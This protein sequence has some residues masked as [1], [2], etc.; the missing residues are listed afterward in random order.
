MFLGTRAG[1]AGSL[2]GEATPYFQERTVSPTEPAPAETPAAGAQQDRVRILDDPHE[3]LQARIDLIEQAERTLDVSYYSFLYGPSTEAVIALLAD[4]ADRGVRV[5]LILD[6]ITNGLEPAYRPILAWLLQHENLEVRFFNPPRGERHLP[7]NNRLHIKILMADDTQ[8]ISGGRNI[9]DEYFGIERGSAKRQSRD[10]DLYIR[11]LPD[12]D[13]VTR[14]VAEF[15]QELWDA[16]TTVP[17]DAESLLR[18]DNE[19]AQKLAV[20]AATAGDE[21]VERFLGYKEHPEIQF[22]FDTG[23]D[24]SEDAIPVDGI[25]FVP[26]PI[27]YKTEENGIAAGVYESFARARDKVVIQSPYVIPTKRMEA[28]FQDMRDRGV[29]VEI[30][31]NSVKSSPNVMALSGYTYYRERMR[32]RG[33]RFWEFAGDYNLHAKSYVVDDRLSMLGS[34]NFDARSFVTNSE[35]MYLV[36]GEAF[37]KS[38]TEIIDAYRAHAEEVLEKRSPVRGSRGKEMLVGALSLLAPITRR[39]L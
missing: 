38:M 16:P 33:V 9:G 32:Q 20:K 8:L 3:A 18:T 23:T 5:R 31:T 1:R 14:Q 17:P 12:E 30:L 21:L 35:I 6:G 2:P 37:A 22:R 29:G 26:D 7:V 11:A 34:V 15:Y 13:G 39:Y 27:L 25:T 36:E 28:S 4:A 19:S 10:R 24:W